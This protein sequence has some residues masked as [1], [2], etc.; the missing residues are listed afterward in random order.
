[1]NGYPAA[2]ISPEAARAPRRKS[3]LANRVYHKTRRSNGQSPGAGGVTRIFGGSWAAIGCDRAFSSRFCG[4][5]A[6]GD[7]GL[8][9][10]ER[11]AQVFVG[12]AFVGRAFQPVGSRPSTNGK[13]INECGT[14]ARSTGFRRTGFPAR[15]FVGRAFQPVRSRPSTNGERTNEC[16]A[17]L[18]LFTVEHSRRGCGTVLRPSSANQRLA[19]HLHPYRSFVA[20]FV[21]GP[22]DSRAYH[23]NKLLKSVS[24]RHVICLRF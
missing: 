20:V 8:Q 18:R 9:T 17:G 21:D 19:P 22:P 14:N 15:A 3:W 5:S 4:A 6:N 24:E 1:M 7:N 23:Q 12:R 11:V 13:R 10:A 16:R 2:G